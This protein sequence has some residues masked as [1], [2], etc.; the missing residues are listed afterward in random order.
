M[1]MPCYCVSLLVAAKYQERTWQGSWRWACWKARR[2]GCTGREVEDRMES[3]TSVNYGLFECIPRRSTHLDL[4]Y[5]RDW[6]TKGYILIIMPQFSCCNKYYL[7]VV[8]ENSLQKSSTGEC[9]WRAHS[10]G[11][12]CIREVAS[13]PSILRLSP[14]TTA[15]RRVSSPIRLVSHVYLQ[16]VCAHTSELHL[17][18]SK[19]RQ[20]I[21]LNWI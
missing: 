8:R 12:S 4:G 2:G 14:G 13:P 16:L 3:W 17:K 11:S 19:K 15:L 21:C 10:G 18:S 20:E 1:W 6:A 7:G 9:R 5:L